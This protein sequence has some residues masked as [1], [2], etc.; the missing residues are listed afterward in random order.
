MANRLDGKVAVVTGAGSGIGRAGATAMAAEGARVVIAEIDSE[1]GE[2][3]AAAIAAADGEAIADVVDVTDPGAVEALTNRTVERWGS[4][5][6]LLHCAVD[7][8]FVNNEDAR[9]TE[10]PDEVWR[11]MLDLVLTG[12]FNCAK[13]AGRRMIE[14]G[15]GSIILTATTDALI[16]CA[17]LDAYTAA[18]GGVV[19][20]TRSFAAGIARDGVRVN[21]IA[22]SFVSSESQRAWMDNEGAA[23]AVDA[24]HLLP[25]PTPEQIAPLVVYLA[26]AESAAMTGAVIP[27]DSGYMAFKADLDVVD[28]MRAKE[29]EA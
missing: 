1:R 2:R 24:L 13:H 18:K 19:A 29:E 17:G 7:V 23:R 16:G 14:Q 27:I 26:G 25:V 5:D 28:A 15:S 22:P 11:R 21:A 10:L 8:P 20:L 3:V 12:T 9:L 6:V 4:L